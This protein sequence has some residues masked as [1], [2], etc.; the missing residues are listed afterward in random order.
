MTGKVLLYV[1]FTATNHSPYAVGRGTFEDRNPLANVTVLGVQD[2]VSNVKFNGRGIPASGV[3]SDVE[4]KVLRVRG[5]EKLTAGGAYMGDW[6]M[7]W[8]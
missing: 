1:Q 6:V 2:E 7:R 4:R 5:L 8:M 3:D